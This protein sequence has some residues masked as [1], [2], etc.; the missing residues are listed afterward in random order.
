[1]SKTVCGSCGAVEVAT[2]DEKG[3]SMPGFGQTGDKPGDGMQPVEGTSMARMMLP[4]SA[5]MVRK[6]KRAKKRRLRTLG[7]VPA[8]IM[9]GK[10]AED[11]LE[12][13]V[14]VDAFLCGMDRKVYDGAEGPCASCPGGC[15]SEKGLPTILEIEGMAEE[16][17]GMKILG[18]GYGSQEDVFVVQME[19]KD[20]EVVEAYYR[21]STGEL[22][23]FITL[24]GELLS[25]KSLEEDF[26][27]ITTD[28]AM[29]VAL[30][31]FDGG[32]VLAVAADNFEGQDAWVVEMVDGNGADVDVY[33]G[34]DGTTLGYDVYEKAMNPDEEEEVD[35]Q[36]E[37]AATA[38]ADATEAVAEANDQQE[39]DEEKPKEKSLGSSVI[40]D[41]EEAAR[42]AAQ[43]EELALIASSI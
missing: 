22:R 16:D 33:V 15:T 9:E 1:M 24:E 19:R 27:V 8:K 28:E 14:D 2:I 17:F 4:D 40:N 11:F 39:E 6:R 25:G 32:E 5:G 30:K 31:A 29:Q 7:A 10:S 37:D 34:L 38:P 35:E 18:S 13:D 12:S 43:L 3:I 21:G 36:V 41:A 20:G 26:Q 42:I 23:G